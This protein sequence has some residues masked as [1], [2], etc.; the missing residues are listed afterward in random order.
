MPKNIHV[1]AN[2]KPLTKFSACFLILFAVYKK[3]VI[4]AKIANPIMLVVIPI[5]MLLSI[6][7]PTIVAINIFK[8]SRFAML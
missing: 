4:L 7:M 3:T 2:T 8:M 1:A 6:S 5:L